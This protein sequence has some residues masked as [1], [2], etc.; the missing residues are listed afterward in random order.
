MF[1]S[2]V[3]RTREHFNIILSFILEGAFS[4]GPEPEA[5]RDAISMD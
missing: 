5:I 2:G 3:M 1:I 4:F